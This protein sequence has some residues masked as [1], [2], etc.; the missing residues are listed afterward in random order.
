M[1][2]RLAT[3][4]ALALLPFASPA[5][6]DGTFFQFDLSETA[7]D[8]VISVARGRLTFSANWSRYEDGESAG[9]SVTWSIPVE[10]LGTFKLGP[11]LGA[12]SEDDDLEL[13]LK[14]GFE[15]YQPTSF[16]HLFM[17]AEINSIDSGWFGT[18]QTGFNNGFG[19]ELSAGGSDTYDATTL[20]VTHR[21]GAGPVS[22]RAGYKFVAQEV[23]VGL[24]VNTF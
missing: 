18:L 3:V 16:G 13:G 15:R 17:L 20:A 5:A 14:A 9:A 19:V 24:S 7:S 4:A 11:S 23:F 12:N 10:S 21:L 1:R 2:P 6:A 8:A 22:L